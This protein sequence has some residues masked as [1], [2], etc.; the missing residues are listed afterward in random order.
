M[1]TA[2]TCGYS[3]LDFAEWAQQE[4]SAAGDHAGV[5]AYLKSHILLEAEKTLWNI[6]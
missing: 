4:S 6:V 2:E 1:N 5:I 3:A